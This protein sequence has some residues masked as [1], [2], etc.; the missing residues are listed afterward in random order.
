MEAKLAKKHLI[1]PQ[2]M[3]LMIMIQKAN[4]FIFGSRTKNIIRL[5]YTTQG[6][7]ETFLI[8][9]EVFLANDR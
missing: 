5:I 8:R 3:R 2:E 6:E 9:L 7:L 4:S 1:H